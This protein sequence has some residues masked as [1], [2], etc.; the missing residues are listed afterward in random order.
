MLRILSIAPLEWTQGQEYLLLALRKLLDANVEATLVLI[1]DGLE[2][3]RILYT[4][5]DLELEHAV[6]WMP[7]V[8]E[9]ALDIYLS[10][11]DLFVSAGVTGP[12]PSFLRLAARAHIPVVTTPPPEDYPLQTFGVAGLVVPPRDADAMASAF[13]R[14]SH[15]PLLRTWMRTS[16]PDLFPGNGSR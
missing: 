7:F 4:I 15:S 3:Q 9:S 10:R 16:A 1:G 11:S 14:L 2:R 5:F 13:H 6:Q 12:P 8:T